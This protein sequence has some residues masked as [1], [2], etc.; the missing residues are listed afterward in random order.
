M[1]TRIFNPLHTQF[2]Y[3]IDAECLSAIFCPAFLRFPCYNIEARH[4]RGKVAKS[5][6]YNFLFFFEKDEH[7]TSNIQSFAGWT[8]QFPML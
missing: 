1:R 6:L 3:H 2:G 5:Q 4:L 7:N 8:G